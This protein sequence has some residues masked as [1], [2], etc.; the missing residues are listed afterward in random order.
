MLRMALPPERNVHAESQAVVPLSRAD[1]HRLQT[2]YRHGG[3][4]APDGFAAYQLDDGYFFGI[5]DTDGVL[6]ALGGTHIVYRLD[7]PRPS[8][9]NDSLHQHGDA[10][11][12][13]LAQGVAAVGNFYTKPD[14]RGRGYGKA[15]TAAII[16]ALRVDGYGMIVLNVSE[17]NIAARSLYERLGFTTHCQFV[18]GCAA[19]SGDMDAADRNGREETEVSA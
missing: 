9:W 4:F 12:G 16:R 8:D 6:A 13:I 1:G 11:D 15:V 14:F 3:D 19:K 7:R 17:R 5:E 18:E 10:L 2:L